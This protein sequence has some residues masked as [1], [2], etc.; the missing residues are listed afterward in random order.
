MPD[1]L[2]L[3]GAIRHKYDEQVA[4]GAIVCDSVQLELVA[5]LDQLASDI[6][7][8]KLSSKS[9]ALGWLFGQK[10]ADP[11][12][13][14]GL[15]IWGGVGRGKTFLMDLFF[16]Q[17]DTESKRRVHFH[18]FMQEVHQ[19]IHNHRQIF[20]AGKTREKD[21]IVSV[22]RLLAAKAKLLCFDEFSVSDITDAMLLSRLFK[23]LFDEGV[24]VV[25]TSNIA[26]RDLYKE[27]LNRQLF[28]PFIELLQSKMNIYEMVSASDYRLSKLSSDNLYNWPLNERAI[29]AMDLA[30]GMLTDNAAPHKEII[31]LK[32]RQLTVPRAARG[33][34]RFHF[35]QLCREPRG[36]SDYLAIA[37]RYK[38]IMIDEIPVLLAGERNEAKRFI[39]LIDIL[40]DNHNKL[41]V[42]ANSPPELIYQAN[43]GKEALEIERTASRLIEMQSQEYNVAMET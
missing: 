35:D 25:A 31:Q 10:N 28:L 21:P 7:A 2:H 40:Y 42:S 11:L 15:Y 36:A 17:V 39:S 24:I 37:H 32:G 38:S 3:L 43:S 16:T 12:S 9:S 4:S 1:E 23:S 22:A 18:D 8:K 5:R 14:Q 27:G 29:R 19:H 41:V 13:R 33:V 30:W 6:A 26:P 34:C 20:K